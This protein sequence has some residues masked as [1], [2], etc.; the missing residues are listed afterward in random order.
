MRQ[1]ESKRGGIGT[2]IGF[3]AGVGVG[4]LFATRPGS[5][6]RRQL[7]DLLRKGR[8]KGEDLAREGREK[9][10]DISGKMKSQTGKE[11]F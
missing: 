10:E 5:E 2:F 9:V 11:P 1:M 8:E 3:L 4:L 6:T 7:G